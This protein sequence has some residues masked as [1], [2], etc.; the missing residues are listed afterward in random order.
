MAE[1]RNCDCRSK[2]V[3]FAL[4]AASAFD[5]RLG[6]LALQKFVY[7]FDLLALAWREIGGSETFRPWRNGP[8][9]LSIQNTV[10]SLAFRG[11]TV[12]NDLSFRRTRNT[13]CNY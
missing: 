7:L 2:D 13:E 4:A 8:Y 3:L 9:D 6:R 1:E 12:I 10:D 11:L 5:Q